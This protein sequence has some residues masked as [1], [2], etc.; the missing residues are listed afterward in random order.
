MVWDDWQLHI[1]ALRIHFELCKAVLPQMRTQK[2][3]RIVFL[4][5]GLAYRYYSGCA[6][7]STIKAGLN[8]F[9]K[10]LAREEGRK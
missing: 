1:E 5:G 10:C 6:A 7:F 3:G 2:Y 8:A 4:S 9:C